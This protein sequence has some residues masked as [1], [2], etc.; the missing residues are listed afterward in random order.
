MHDN[1]SL[2]LSEVTIGLYLLQHRASFLVIQDQIYIVSVLEYFLQAQH[3]IAF[4]DL[5]VNLDLRDHVFKYPPVCRH[6]PLFLN[7]DCKLLLLLLLIQI[8]LCSLLIC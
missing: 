7:L 5:P 6:L 4:L 1:L 8:H 3:A 2:W